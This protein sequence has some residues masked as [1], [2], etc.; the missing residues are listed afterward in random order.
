MNGPAMP[1][2]RG[3]SHLYGS[4]YNII[5]NCVEMEGTIRSVD[6]GVRMAV[7]QRIEQIAAAQAAVFGADA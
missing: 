4:Q 3:R 5:P 6:N 2:R 7:A 1:A